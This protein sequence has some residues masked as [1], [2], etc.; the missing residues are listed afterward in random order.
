M[1]SHKFVLKEGGVGKMLKC[2]EEGIDGSRQKGGDRM[3][4]TEGRGQS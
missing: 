4:G 1:W 2:S 3:E